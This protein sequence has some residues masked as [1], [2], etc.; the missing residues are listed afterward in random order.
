MSFSPVIDRL[1]KQD[2]DV[3][4]L[5][6]AH[7][8]LVQAENHLRL[9]YYKQLMEYLGKVNTSATYALVSSGTNNVDDLVMAAKLLI[10]VDVF[11]LSVEDMKDGHIKLIPPNNLPRG[12]K[13]TMAVHV[14]SH[15]HRLVKILNKK[16]L[17]KDGLRKVLNRGCSK[18]L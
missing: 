15:L 5:N 11:S 8:F 1:D 13:Q 12:R 9:A 3:D 18:G 14:A 2:T 10:L 17:P 4:H 16:N 6:R 7:T